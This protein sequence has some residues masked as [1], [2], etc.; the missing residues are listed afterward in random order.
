MAADQV[1]N[2]GVIIHPGLAAIRE[3]VV[4]SLPPPRTFGLFTDGVDTWWP[5][6]YTWS[7]DALVAM[8]LEPEPG[9]RCLELGP[10]GFQCH[11]GRVLECDAPRRLRFSWQIGPHR[12]PVPDRSLA[13]EVEV[14]F[15]AQQEGT[16][17]VVLEHRGFDRHGRLGDAYR[18]A[19]ASEH[20]WPYLL[21]EFAAAAS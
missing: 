21:S 19:L 3:E 12:E 13:S 15:V 6:S 5:R 17:R 8:V 4:V 11:W 9:G 7:G 14:T 20:G 2:G 1:K 10:D 18:E 16:T